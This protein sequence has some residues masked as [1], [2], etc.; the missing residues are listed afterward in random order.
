[1]RDDD[2]SIQLVDFEGQAKPTNENVYEN[3]KFKDNLQRELVEEMHAR[4]R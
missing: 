4:E 2:G 3:P 1:M